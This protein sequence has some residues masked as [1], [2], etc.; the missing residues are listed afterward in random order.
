MR[1]SAVASLLVLAA[2]GSPAPA[3]ADAGA[4]ASLELP[5]AGADAGPGRD[6]G[7]PGLDAGPPEPLLSSSLLF[8]DDFDG[9]ADVQA[10]RA[11]YP[12]LR[13]QG[14]SIALERDGGSA[15][16]LD[17]PARASCG[18]ADVHVGKVVA[19]DVP[20]V[21]VT[22][23]FRLPAGFSACDGGVS[24][25]VLGRTAGATT[26]LATAGAWA[27]DTGTARF[28]QHLRLE[29]HAPA[30]VAREAWHR[31]TLVVT[32][33]S[34]VGA[35]DGVV[36]AWLDG[37]LLIDRVGATGTAPFSLATWPGAVQLEAA[38]SRWIDDLAIST[39]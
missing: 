19:G 23:R 38:Q 2:C 16:R 36:Q 9:Y 20:T 5:D 32:R 1:V 11:A 12:E 34:A 14:G 13:E 27:L 18:A 37:A 31:V 22:W 24:H 30:L 39:P 6:A 10:L 7:Q 28:E 26:F 35:G 4:D 29:S 8:R 3:P 21:M 15:L 33:E 25:F 17:Y